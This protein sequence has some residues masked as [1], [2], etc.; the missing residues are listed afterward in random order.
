MDITIT[1]L[2]AIC[3][4]GFYFWKNKRDVKRAEISREQLRHDTI[5]YQHIRGGLR[6]Y[7]WKKS[8]EEGFFSKVFDSNDKDILLENAHLIVYR[9]RHFSEFRL[10]FFFKDIKQYGL[11]GN[12][13]GWERYYRTDESFNKEE[14]LCY[15]DDHDDD[16]E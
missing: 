15:D 6:E 9:V 4:G 7:E 14:I 13:E 3:L 2:L 8:T 10:G 16:D 5:L 12:F 1:S 11:Y